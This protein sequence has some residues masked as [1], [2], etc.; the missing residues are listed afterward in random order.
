MIAGVG[1]FLSIPSNFKSSEGHG[2]KD[3]TLAGKLRRIDYA[4][5][6]LLV[7]ASVQTVFSFSYTSHTHLMLI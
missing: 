7:C 2:S 5:A 4:G 1:V 6:V 3:E